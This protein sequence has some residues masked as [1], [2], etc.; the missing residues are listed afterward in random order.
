MN[1]LIR[2]RSASWTY[3]TIRCERSVRTSFGFGAFAMIAGETRVKMEEACGSGAGLLVRSRNLCSG[4][5]RSSDL[6]MDIWR[7]RSSIAGVCF[8]TH[9]IS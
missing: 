8:G 7:K 3:T 5:I 2:G 1:K 4:G 9:D 6:D